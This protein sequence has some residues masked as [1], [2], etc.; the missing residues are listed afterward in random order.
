[1]TLAPG[2]AGVGHRDSLHLLLQGSQLHCGLPHQVPCTSLQWVWHKSP[3]S[4]TKRSHIGTRPAMGT[5]LVVGYLEKSVSALGTRHRVCENCIG[6]FSWTTNSSRAE[7]VGEACE[8]DGLRGTETGPRAPHQISCTADTQ[9]A[10]TGKRVS[11]RANTA[12]ERL[13][14]PT[15]QTTTINGIKSTAMLFVGDCSVIV[16]VCHLLHAPCHWRFRSARSFA[17]ERFAH[18]RLGV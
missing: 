15:K 5:A 16:Q 17:T 12:S 1:M 6:P 10:G 2:R 11:R 8:K 18:L 4:A 13:T 3:C 14:E 7:W 9:L